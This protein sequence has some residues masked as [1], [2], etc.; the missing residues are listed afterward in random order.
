MEQKHFLGNRVQIRI[1]TDVIPEKDIEC[2]VG[3]ILAA[4]Y[5]HYWHVD[6]KYHRI[7][8]TVVLDRNYWGSMGR[9]L[10]VNQDQI[11]ANKTLH[12]D[13]KERGK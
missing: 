13:R 6:T 9:K 3:V 5:V 4:F 10:R 8:Y 7:E 11:I 12:V 1:G 2:D